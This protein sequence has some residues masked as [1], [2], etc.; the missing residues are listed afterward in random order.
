MI[1]SENMT[2]EEYM[3]L[4]NLDKPIKEIGEVKHVVNNNTVATDDDDEEILCLFNHVIDD[5]E[6]STTVK[7]LSEEETNELFK[8]IVDVINDSNVD[9]LKQ[10]PEL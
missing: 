1:P 3:M 10:L 7:E 6:D 5:P 8:D 9:K 2:P 4:S